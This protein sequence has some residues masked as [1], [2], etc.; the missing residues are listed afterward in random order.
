MAGFQGFE[1]ANGILQDMYKGL[2]SSVYDEASPLM[3]IIKPKSDKVYGQQVKFSA[4][5]ENPQGVASR[6]TANQL[7]PAAVPGKYLELIIPTGRIYGVMEFDG[8]MLEAAGANKDGKMA[9]VNYLENEI[10]GL[11]TAFNMDLSRQLFGKKTGFICA[12]GTTAGLVILQLATTAN[13]Q[14]FVEGM[15]IDILTA[16]TGVAIANGL[17]RVIQSVDVDNLRVT[18]DT[19]GGVVTTDSTISVCRQ[20]AYNAEMTGLAAI[21]SDTENIYGVI[22]STQRR[23]KGYVYSTAFAL[24]IKTIGK[25]A[26]AAKTRSGVFTDLIVSS[27]SKMQQI[28]ATIQ[29]TAY[30]WDI[31]KTPTPPTDIKLGYNRLYVLIEG[32]L[33]EWISDPNC[34]ESVI[35]GLRKEYLGIQHL[36]DPKFMTVNGEML[37]PNIYGANGTPTY[38]AV[39]EY[40]PEYTCQRRNVNWV[41]TGVTDASG[42]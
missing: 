17:D 35:Y 6:A 20:G 18:L 25:I 15:H 3:K 38:K 31:G 32:N 40:Y 23:W 11:K 9:Y 7:L 16:A 39:L 26:M 5:L 24:N 14:Y 28:G 42:W 12:S 2:V 27:P 13:M 22:T 34:P 1:V 37:L 29:G 19:S 4:Q 36:G 30:T 33:M 41:A 21:V 8:K 10:K